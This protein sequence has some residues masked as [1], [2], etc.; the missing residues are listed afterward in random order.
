MPLKVAA[1]FA[2]GFV[3]MS[4][5]VEWNSAAGETAFVF[6]PAL[7]QLGV[8][9][10]AFLWQI[11]TIVLF[12]MVAFWAVEGSFADKLIQGVKSGAEILAET[13]AKS[14][15]VD[16]PM[17]TVG[18]GK[19]ES[20]FSLGSVLAAPSA[21]ANAK[22]AKDNQ[23]KATMAQA[24]GIT[25][26]DF[27]KGLQGKIFSSAEAFKTHLFSAGSVGEAGS[28]YKEIAEALRNSQFEGSTKLADLFLR[29]K[30]N[31]KNIN[32]EIA[33][34]A[35]DYGFKLG[36]NQF[37]ASPESYGKKDSSTNTTTDTPAEN[38]A[39]VV[40][41]DFKNY[42]EA[43]N[44]LKGKKDIEPEDS[45]AAMNLAG[46][47]NTL[48]DAINGLGVTIKKGIYIDSKEQAYMHLTNESSGAVKLDLSGVNDLA[49]L[50]A[51]MLGV[52]TGLANE[53]ITPQMKNVLLA[54][55]G[56]S[57]PNNYTWNSGSKNFTKNQ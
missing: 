21:I 40:G 55:A 8:N 7:S 42:T 36:G 47:P 24:F 16:R 15:T 18:T 22:Q 14:L 29:E 52:P 17:F 10:Y 33:K 56:I 5:M 49:G 35:I 19:N 3:M 4:A 9:E 57:D 26:S 13:T 50:N 12:W 34:S 23:M 37:L 54:K 20:Q 45:A 38:K 30:G 46:A 44:S 6:G 2:V 28:H 32:D 39:K 48:A 27:A 1:A 51:K 41:E 31:M 25:Q 43:K 11:A 53:V